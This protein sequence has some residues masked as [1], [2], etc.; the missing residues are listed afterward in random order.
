M[1]S[2]SPATNPEAL[3][4]A[5]SQ[6]IADHP[7]DAI[8]GGGS[9]PR[10]RVRPEEVAE[11][12]GASRLP[13]GEA[14]RILAVEGLI[15]QESNKVARVPGLDSRE[16]DIYQI[17]ERL[18][19]LALSLSITHLT[20]D[21][22]CRLEHIQGQIETCSDV[23]GCLEL[24]R[25]LH[26]LTYAGCH[27]DQPTSMVTRLWNCTQHYRRAF[28]PSCGAARMW[29]T[30]G[31]HRLL[32]EAIRRRD[33]TGAECYLNGHIRRT[34]VEMTRHPQVVDEAPS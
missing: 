16:V 18:E 11:R 2:T 31:K 6:Q 26:L 20:E 7:P 28:M 29:V 19:R 27:G 13:L 14:P 25:E 24:D 15:E 9:G 1:T 34:Q 30:N 3:P 12:F 22:L 17:L 21:Y 23:S 33:S 10:Q 32:L 4:G 8:L 5:V